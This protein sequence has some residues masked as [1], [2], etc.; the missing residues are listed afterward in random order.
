MYESLPCFSKQYQVLG[1]TTSTCNKRTGHKCKKRYHEA[2]IRSSC[3][4]PSTE[5]IVVEKQQP[6]SEGLHDEP[7]IYPMS[8]EVATTMEERLVSPWRKRIKQA[9]AGHSGAKH[10]TSLNVVHVSDD[11]NVIA[12]VKPSTRQYLTHSRVA[13][14]TSSGQQGRHNRVT[15]NSVAA[16]PRRQSRSDDFSASSSL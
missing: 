12:D 11:R 15:K 3:S 4:S 9:E 16:D 6:Y 10:S 2:P 7:S 1:H 14:T 13:M 5:T 8:A